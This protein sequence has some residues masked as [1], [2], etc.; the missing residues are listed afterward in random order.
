MRDISLQPGESIGPNL[1]RL[2]SFV[3]GGEVEV[4]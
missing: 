1:W 4:G 3:Q 2:Y